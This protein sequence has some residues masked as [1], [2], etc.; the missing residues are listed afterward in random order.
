MEE[1]KENCVTRFLRN[2]YVFMNIYLFLAAFICYFCVYAYR[3]PFSVATYE[4]KTLFGIEYKIVLITLQVIGYT[5]SK[6]S[7]IKVISEL[8]KKKRPILILVLIAFAEAAII[9]FGC[10]PYPYNCICMFLN[11][12]PLGLLWG[13][14]FSYL[15][16]RRTS[17]LLGSGL[18]VS[19]I[20]GSGGVKSVGKI[21][22]ELSSK[23][24]FWMPSI[25]GAIFFVPLLISV[26]MLESAPWPDSEDVRLKKPRT[27]M[28]HLDRINLFKRFA[29]GLIVITLFYMSITAYRDFRDNFAAELWEAFGYP[30]APAIFTTSEIIVAIVVV[31]PIGLFMIIKS[32]INV[33][34]TYHIL[35][36]GGMIIVG[37]STYLFHIEVLSGLYLMIITGIGVY[38]CYLPFNSI[39]FDLLI[40]TFE[41]QG[42]SGF[43]MYICDS[44]G[45]LS[46][47][48][49][50]LVKNFATPDLSW[51][52]FYKTFSI[53][54]SIG[55]L[56]LVSLSALYFKI[57][58]K[59]FLYDKENRI[60]DPTRDSIPEYSDIEQNKIPLLL[61]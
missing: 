29:P 11:G 32:N 52:I 61:P 18:C 41:V 33:L 5:I 2:H 7:G 57:K 14:V 4:G 37:V 30:E 9:L 21:F 38:L 55:G 35:M 59:K 27:P 23:L 25:V 16:G 34:M 60:Y 19:F 20:V 1:E 6:F 12:L 46:S 56:I 31:I 47:V 53:G 8:N 45:Y 36:I 40:T 51:S 22:L 58:H 39:I 13:L 17:S 26:L 48:G 3:K 28:S 49:L 50:M 10:I 15:E 24:Q 44:F 42:N 43:L 54:L